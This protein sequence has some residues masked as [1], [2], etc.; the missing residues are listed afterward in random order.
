MPAIDRSLSVFARVPVFLKPFAND[1]DTFAQNEVSDLCDA[2][3]KDWCDFEDAKN[4]VERLTFRLQGV[5]VFQDLTTFMCASCQNTRDTVCPQCTDWDV[6]MH[7]PAGAKL[8]EMIASLGRYIDGTAQDSGL[9]PATPFQ[10]E[11]P[12]HPDSGSSPTSLARMI[13]KEATDAAGDLSRQFSKTIAGTEAEQAVAKLQADGCFLHAAFQL[14][15]VMAGDHTSRSLMQER[16]ERIEARLRSQRVSTEILAEGCYPIRL[17]DASCPQS[18]VE[19]QLRKGLVHSLVWCGT[20]Y[21]WEERVESQGVTS[22]EG[23]AEIIKQMPTS[24]ALPRVAV[25]CLQNGAHRAAQLFA[26]VGVQQVIWI[27]VDIFTDGCVSIFCDVILPAVR[28][29]QNTGS[30]GQTSQL[31]ATKMERLGVTQL[32]GMC[33]CISSADS[34]EKWSPAQSADKHWWCR[35]LMA[36][37]LK[38]INLERKSS[39]LRNLHLW[40]CDLRRLNDLR[41]ELV[42]SRCLIVLSRDAAGPV[43]RLRSLAHTVCQQHLHGTQYEHVIRVTNLEDMRKADQSVRGPALLWLDICLG[44]TT[45]VT[46]DAMQDIWAEHLCIDAHLLVT[47]NDANTNHGIYLD[48]LESLCVAWELEEFHLRMAAGVPGVLADELCDDVKITVS[49]ES[50]TSASSLLDVFGQ[51]QL[52]RA[53]QIQAH[54]RPVVGIY[55]ADEEDAIVVRLSFSDVGFVH[56]LRDQILSD[57]FGCDVECALENTVRKNGFENMGKASISVDRTQFAVRYSSAILK[58]DKLTPHQTLKLHECLHSTIDVSLRAAAGAGKTFV[59]LNV[60]MKVLLGTQRVIFVAKNRP[61]AMMM[62]KWVSNRCRREHGAATRKRVMSRLHLMFAPLEKGPHSVE[63]VGDTLRTTPTSVRATYDLQV[64]DEA[65]HIYGDEALRKVLERD[66]TCHRRILL[67]DI[68]QGVHTAAFPRGL[69]EVSLTEVVRSSKRVVAGAMRFQLKGNDS[70]PIT[71]CHHDSEGPPLKSFVFN[72][73]R[74]EDRLEKYAAQTVE[75]LQHVDS[76]FPGL[77]LHNQLAIIVPDAGFRRRLLQHL[78]RRLKEVFPSRLFALV[79]ANASACHDATTRRPDATPATEWLVLDEISQLDGMEFLMVVCTAL[80]TPMDS[81]DSTILETRS[82]L[83]RAV[84]RAVMMVMAVNEAIF[85]GWF[86]FLKTVRLREDR[87][88]DEVKMEELEMAATQIEAAA[89][90]QRKA[91]ARAAHLVQ[92][93]SFL[94]LTIG[95]EGCWFVKPD[96]TA[97]FLRGLREQTVRDEAVDIWYKEQQ[98]SRVVALLEYEQDA[99]LRRSDVVASIVEA[100]SI[101]VQ[102]I[103][104]EISQTQQREE[105]RK[106]RETAVCQARLKSERERAESWKKAGDALVSEFSMAQYFTGPRVE[107]LLRLIYSSESRRSRDTSLVSFYQSQRDKTVSTDLNPVDAYQWTR[108]SFRVH[109]ASETA[110][111]EQMTTMRLSAEATEMRRAEELC[112]TQFYADGGT[113]PILR[114]GYCTAVLANPDDDLKLFMKARGL[115]VWYPLFNGKLK[116]STRATSGNCNRYAK[117]G[118]NDEMGNGT[119]SY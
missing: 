23:L 61:L 7:G 3:M 45:D 112:M 111:V 19:L 85:G 102:G 41:R 88:F 114:L 89:Q 25:V 42:S 21:G 18:P 73:A 34:I 55:H 60:M 68:S 94:H 43:T 93:G 24:C 13:Q 117:A 76:T 79:D 64:V 98:R 110:E 69:K 74:G 106:I 84:T 12:K 17:S 38:G 63:L 29:L 108:R 57:Q 96:V 10:P 116:F 1:V 31:V 52:V 104:A 82:M 87:R 15:Q 22:L 9:F 113:E 32:S 44:K 27:T 20:G 35:S 95:N 119:R 8:D 50:A 67:S 107:P 56:I 48:R 59:A 30:V 77:N 62:A 36:T 65:H 47:L 14:P 5:P 90:R 39:T 83:Y 72:V 97:G 109:L 105:Q 92:K 6:V 46:L 16:F 28:S 49:F 71:K 51:D 115:K 86:G 101:K 78:E 91:E 37:A 53:L 33:G 70:D 100:T 118:R 11:S 4:T 99:A 80:D 103:N 75:A 2:Y 54:E 40:A 81:A 66:I 58:L 26:S